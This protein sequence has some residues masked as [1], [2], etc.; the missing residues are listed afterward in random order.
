MP[1]VSSFYGISIYMYNNGKEHAPPHFH[2]MCGDDECVFSIL[3]CRKIN[4][5]MP[6]N[7]AKMIEVWAEI[8]QDELLANW[9][10]AMKQQAL[11]KINPLQ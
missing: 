4:G 3:R 10:L 8:H 2:A 5:R 9:E 1:I 6:K 7:K 11:M